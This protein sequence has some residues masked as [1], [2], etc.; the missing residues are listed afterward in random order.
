VA[1]FGDVELA[2]TQGV[3][4]LD[5]LVA[6]ARN[7]LSVLGAESTRQ[8]VLGVSDKSAS[9][10]ACLDVPQSESVVPRGRQ[11]EMAVRGDHDILNEVRV[12]AKTLVWDAGKWDVSIANITMVGVLKVPHND[13]FVT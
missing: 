2:L 10:L 12:A 3:P 13:G 8:N 6:R 5:S 11:S 1:I 4:E 7:N 9:G